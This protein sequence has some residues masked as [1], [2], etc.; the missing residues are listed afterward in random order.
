MNEGFLTGHIT[1]AVV[2]I[3]LGIYFSYPSTRP[4]ALSAKLTILRPLP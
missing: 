4:E 2:R 1:Y 3:R